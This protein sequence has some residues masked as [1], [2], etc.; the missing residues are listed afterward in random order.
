MPPGQ[1]AWRELPTEPTRRPPAHPR[2]LILPPSAAA[3]PL[4]LCPAPAWPITA[5]RLGHRFLQPPALAELLAAPPARP[6]KRRRGP[7]VTARTRRETP[8]VKPLP[9]ACIMR[10]RHFA[11]RATTG[12]QHGFD[13]RIF[14]W[15]LGNLPIHRKRIPP[16]HHCGTYWRRPRS[17]CRRTPLSLSPPRLTRELNENTPG[18]TPVLLMRAR[19]RSP[20]KL[21]EMVSHT[22]PSRWW[23]DGWRHA[24]VVPILGA[25]R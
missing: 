19:F 15:F 17:T 25:S 10:S 8:S 6:R 2:Q 21:E 13:A 5:P 20:C 3:G 24:R 4:V 7:V 18:E 22:A 16:R 11:H 12:T 9:C 23:T 14:G 1:S